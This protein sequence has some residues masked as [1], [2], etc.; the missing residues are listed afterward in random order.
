VNR[1]ALAFVGLLA[2]GLVG[3]LALLAPGPAEAVPD[4]AVSAFRR[5][6][7]HRCHAVTPGIEAAPRSESC[8][9]CHLWIRGVA[10]DPVKR[11]KA[12]ALFPLWPR[13][14]RTVATYLDVPGLEAAMARVDPAWIE[15]YLADPHDLRPGLSETMPRF[16]LSDDERRA[17][18]E[19]FREA[20]VKVPAT[21]APD[22]KRLPAGE[23]L[24]KAKGCVGCHAF[25][26]R[27]SQALSP[28]APDLAHTRDR[29]DHDHVAAWIRDP[30]AVSPA[31]KM[32]AVPLSDDEVLALRDY[33]MGA[34]LNW[35]DEPALPALPPLPQRPVKWAEVEERVFGRICVHCHMDP[36]QNEGRRGPGNAGGFGFGATGIEL[37]TPEGV[38][39]AAGLIPD[40]LLRRRAEAHRDVVSAGHRPASLTRPEKPGMPMG[41]PPL[42]DEDITLVLAWIPPGMPR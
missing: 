19:A 6:D 34:E 1:G 21:A 3:G 35:S 2:A 10:A 14:E 31:A 27:W 25:G 30:Q 23:A 8:T 39:R 13:Y 17:I 33:V 18:S 26:D 42:P 7:C 36:A 41:L 11:E 4:A 12:L 15:R 29:M 24:F 38:A 40:A 28:V 32:P 5:G 37:Q 16:A 22:P 9:T 20:L